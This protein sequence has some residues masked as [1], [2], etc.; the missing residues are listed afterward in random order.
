MSWTAG[1]SIASTQQAGL[2]LA[3]KQEETTILV[4]FHE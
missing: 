3:L 4:F 1:D 2:G